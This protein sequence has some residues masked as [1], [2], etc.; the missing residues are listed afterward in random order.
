MKYIH[1]IFKW[2][3]KRKRKCLFS[4]EKHEVSV[5]IMG[6]FFRGVN[7]HYYVEVS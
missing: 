7:K 3:L 4:I 1:V 6:W 2:G 5:H